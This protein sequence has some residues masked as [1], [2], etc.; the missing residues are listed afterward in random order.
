MTSER[1]DELIA[2]A[3]LGE[4]RPQEERELDDAVRADEAV[5]DELAQ[6]LAGA[7][8]IQRSTAEDPPPL[9]RASVMAA[10]RDTPQEGSEAD[11]GPRGGGPK[12]DAVVS[13]TSARR[14]SWRPLLAGVA[15]ATVLLIGGMVVVVSQNDA[16]T[17][18][19]AAVVDAPDAIT[20]VLEG[21]LGGTLLVTYSPSKDAMVVEGQGVPVLGDTETYQ[22]WL[23]DE[24]GAISAGLFRPAGD[25][26]VSERLDGVD[27]TGFGLGVTREPAGGSDSPTLPI[28]A[29]T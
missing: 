10:I 24:G 2:L 15:A 14:R 8:A 9:L 3:A 21:D 26:S 17:D 6:A 11:P 18:D 7:A 5:A 25:G 23:V 13:I 1:I 19:V 16:G 22:L 4:L 12:S 28:I 27:P 29:S 20:E